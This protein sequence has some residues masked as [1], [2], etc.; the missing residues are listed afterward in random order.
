MACM[1]QSKDGVWENPEPNVPL[2]TAHLRSKLGV[3][4]HGCEDLAALEHLNCKQ[5]SV[6]AVLS[7]G[8]ASQANINAHKMQ[9][10]LARPE[11]KLY[12]NPTILFTT[13]IK[14]IQRTITAFDSDSDY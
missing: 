9:R 3:D 6:V 11:S 4:E 10:I 13:N 7:K 5:Q 14:G 2:A 1:A 12:I 8:Q